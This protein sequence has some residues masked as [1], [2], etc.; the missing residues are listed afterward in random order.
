[1]S[2]ASNIKIE[3][4]IKGMKKNRVTQNSITAIMKLLTPG[5]AANTP[6]DVTLVKAFPVEVSGK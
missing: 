5:R 6:C 4:R 3:T 1:M 2:V